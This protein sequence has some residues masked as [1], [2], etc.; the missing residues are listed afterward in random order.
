MNKN[1]CALEH[2][3]KQQLNDEN[4]WDT[5]TLSELKSLYTDNELE[6]T[7]NNNYLIISEMSDNEDDDELNQTSKQRCLN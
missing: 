3:Q 6:I 5:L 4:S 2:A 7:E 1:I